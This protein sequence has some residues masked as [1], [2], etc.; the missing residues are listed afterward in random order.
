MLSMHMQAQDQLPVTPDGRYHVFE[1]REQLHPGW[2]EKMGVFDW[3][4]E[5]WGTTS[6]LI[7]DSYVDHPSRAANDLRPMRAVSSK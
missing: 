4:Q 5:L 1:A 6:V 3:I 2:Q 7:C